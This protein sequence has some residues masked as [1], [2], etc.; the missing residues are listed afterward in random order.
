[1][2]LLFTIVAIGH[3]LL[4]KFWFIDFSYSK[5]IRMAKHFFNFGEFPM[6]SNPDPKKYLD[7]A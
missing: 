7:S 3:G 4:K 5:I 6:K 2:L 1:M